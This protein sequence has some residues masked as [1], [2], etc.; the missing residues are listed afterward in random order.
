MK[1]LDRRD[2]ADIIKRIKRRY[3][4]KGTAF[5]L[6]AAVILVF[7]YIY[8]YNYFADR[9]GAINGLLAIPLGVVIPFFALKLHKDIFDKSWEGTISSLKSHVVGKASVA[10]RSESAVQEYLVLTVHTGNDVIIIDQPATYLNRFKVGDRLRH[11]KGTK[12][13]Q[14]CRKDSTVRDCVMCGCIVRES[15]NECPHCHLSLVK[16]DPPASWAKKEGGK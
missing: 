4:L 11:I 16:F 1:Y 6:L 2:N 15:G 10:N 9:L 14:A 8:A 5:V 12:Y 7:F 3:I 13:M